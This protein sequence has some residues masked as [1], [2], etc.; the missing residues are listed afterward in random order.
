MAPPP[1]GLR[2]RK[3]TATRLAIARA[4]M[5]LFEERGYDGTTVEDIA[6]AANVSRRTFFRYFAGKDEVLIVDPEGKLR[7]LHVALAEGPPEEPTIDA[8]RRGILALTAAYFEPELV[9]AEAR[10][11]YKEPALAAAGLAYQVRW[12][13]ALAQ[14]VADDLRVDIDRD[15]RPRI[16]AHATVAIM[17]AGVASWLGDGGHGEPADAVARTFDLTTPAL[18]AVLAMPVNQPAARRRRSVKA[19]AGRS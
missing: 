6:T 11:V 13:D 12:E 1:D 16:V 8:L 9:L 7:A 5:A 14:E 3:K 18:E 19:S 4:A 10:V 15:P 17:R 2:E